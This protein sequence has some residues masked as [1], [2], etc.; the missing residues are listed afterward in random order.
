MS[1]VSL[2]GILGVGLTLAVCQCDGL[3]AAIVAAAGA[4]PVL[5]GLSSER[6]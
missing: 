3:Q 6:S 2:C 4:W 5:T 1:W